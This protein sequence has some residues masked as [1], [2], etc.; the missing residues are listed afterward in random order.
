MNTPPVGK[1]AEAAGSLWVHAWAV[2]QGRV[3]DLGTNFW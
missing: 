3:L 1:D 2:V